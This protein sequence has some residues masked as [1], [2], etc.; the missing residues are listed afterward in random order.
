[1]QLNKKAIGRLASLSKLEVTPTEKEKLKQELD[2]VIEWISKLNEIDTKAVEPL[3][4]PSTEVN[5][6]RED[7]P[8][9]ED[10][11]PLEASSST[12]D[13]FESPPFK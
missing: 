10:T 12:S 1:M 9:P 3:Y 6:L 7:N 2:K 5:I 4:T 13:Y 11:N 8:A